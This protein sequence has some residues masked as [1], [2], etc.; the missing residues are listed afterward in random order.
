M[1]PVWAMQV[2]EFA[3]FTGNKDVV[4]FCSGRYKNVLLPGQMEKD[5]SFPRELT[6]I[7]IIPKKSC[8]FKGF[9]FFDFSKGDYRFFTGETSGVIL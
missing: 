3:K 6:R 4:K 8:V 9:S 1:V 7:A 2:A 5:G